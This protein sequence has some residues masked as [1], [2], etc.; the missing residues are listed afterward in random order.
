MNSLVPQMLI[1]KIRAVRPELLDW[2]SVVVRTLKDPRRPL[3]IVSDLGVIH[4]GM[5]EQSAVHRITNGAG[6]Y[7][8]KQHFDSSAYA[9]ETANI[10]FINALRP[11]A[12]EILYSD[13]DTGIILME[14]LGDRSLAHLAIN[15]RMQE[16]ERWVRRAFSLV[17]LIQSHFRRHEQELRR[18]YGNRSPESGPYLPLPDGL[19][20][21][22]AE[23]LRTSRGIELESDD[24]QLLEKTD[25]ALRA[26]MEQFSNRHRSFTVDLTPW[27]I[28]E[29]DG[30]I[31]FLDFTRPPIGSLLLQFNVIWRLENRRDIV[32]F[33]LEERA[34]LGLPHVN[35]EEF[36]RL[37]DAV[38]FL[39]CIEWIRH[40]CKDIL[41]GR[42]FLASWDGSKLNDYEGS[43]K[44]NLDAALE[45]VSPHKDFDAVAGLL[46]RYFRKPITRP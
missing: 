19:A 25:A 4:A 13:E 40:Y 23:I 21:A 2:G 32:R 8:I 26:R 44:P 31:R 29:K 20:D 39:E 6:S 12:P 33:Y 34:R 43:E 24:R 36:L 37:Q 30:E 3:S 42:H 17:A 9:R 46:R 14:D 35:T 10:A 7:V 27:H 5:E 38:Q 41:E 15:N 18:L 16:Y 11:I 28:I 22:L 45:A 1:K